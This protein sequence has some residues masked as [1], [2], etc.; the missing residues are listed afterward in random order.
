MMQALTGQIQGLAFHVEH[1]KIAVTD[2]DKILAITMGL[3]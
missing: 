3:P 1:T 2:Q